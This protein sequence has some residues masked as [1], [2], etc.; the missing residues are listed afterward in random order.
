[1]FENLRDAFREAISNFKEE[2]ERDRVPESV[3]RLLVGMRDEVT[4][5]KVQ[6]REL[7]DQLEKARAQADRE[8]REAET[9]RRR[10]RMARDIADDET[11]DELEPA[12]AD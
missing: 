4:S 2:L 8:R 1:M 6:V 12:A 7:E 11:A 3:D 9:A 5:A 10:G